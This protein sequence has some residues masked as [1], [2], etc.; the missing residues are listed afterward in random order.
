MADRKIV[1]ATHGHCF[2]GVVSAAMFTHLRRHTARASL[3][4][5]YLSCGY[6]P[7]LQTIP[8]KWLS[9]DENAILDFRF[10]PSPRLSWYFDHHVTAFASDAERAKALEDS[11]RI[12]FDP[13]YGSCT[14]LIADVGRE[15]FGVRFDRFDELVGWADKIDSA[16]FASALEAIDR[17][18]P[19]IQLA[20]VVEQHGDAALYHRLAER[21]LE[22]PVDDVAQAD[23]IQVLWRPIAAASDDTQ[24]RISKRLITEGVVSYVE[25]PEQPLK[26]SG[27]FVAYALAP[28][29]VY[30]VALVRMKQH[31][32]ISVGY[33]PWC[34]APRRHNI[35]T[36]CQRHG[37]GGHPVVGAVSIPLDKLD[38]AIAL[39][40]EI[41]V[42][43]NQ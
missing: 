20:A 4:F 30:S 17:T 19:V 16:R 12:F 27:K 14:K 32:K 23:D 5:K 15:H 41:V 25:L 6:G 24:S 3:R 18:S 2:D 42:E 38:R 29:C 37:G 10:S 34:Q 26:A 43:L 33:N 9:G 35:A 31:F 36:I 40:R 13:G 39:A 1:V 21:L 7:N 22:A 28:Q 11:E 8:D